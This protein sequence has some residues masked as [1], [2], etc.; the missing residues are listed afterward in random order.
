MKICRRK[1]QM[2]I[3]VVIPAYNEE[4]TI[5]T[6]L[7]RL[8]Q[9]SIAPK[10]QQVIVVDDGSI[11]GTATAVER[12][13][14]AHSLPVHL[15]RK[16]V[17]EGKGAALALV[18]PEI[19]SDI[20]VIQDAD[21]EYHPRD[22]SALLEPIESG[23]AD[24]VFGSR[25]LGGPHRILLFWHYMG[26]RFL[27]LLANLL[28]DLSMTDMETGYKAVRTAMVQRIHFHSKRF[29][30]EPEFTCKMKRLGARMYEVPIGYF[31]RSYDEGKKIGWAD[32]VRAIF[33]LV[34][35]RWFARL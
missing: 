6:V 21:L 10:I 12:F 20:V 30:F 7:K 26:N 18:F 34:W 32:G 16:P 25:F 17:N 11:D 15:K 24:V 5:S 14:M 35:Y 8:S 2:T 9:S 13:C 23:F 19:Q 1:E 33:Q 4:K 3:T 22:L 27:T 28:N 29:G 31:G